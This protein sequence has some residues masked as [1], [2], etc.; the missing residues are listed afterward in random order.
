MVGDGDSVRCHHRHPS[1]CPC[2]LAYG[3]DEAG[4]CQ[5]HLLP[6]QTAT[7]IPR[8][9]AAIL[10]LRHMSMCSK[11]SCHSQ[12]LGLYIP[13]ACTSIIVLSYGVVYYLG[14]IAL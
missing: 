7:T 12:N 3:T 1:A 14:L 13:T 5:V 9:C 8:Y 4:G 11:I 6:G 10:A 2:W